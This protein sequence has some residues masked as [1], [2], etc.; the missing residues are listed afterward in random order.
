MT[1]SETI[2]TIKLAISQLNILAED[3]METFKYNKLRLAVEKLEYVCKELIDK[4]IES[5]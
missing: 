5:V 3:E 1:N 2:E 4:T